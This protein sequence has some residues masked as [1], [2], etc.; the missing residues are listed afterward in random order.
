MYR[1]AKTLLRTAVTGQW[2]PLVLRQG[3]PRLPRRMAWA[4]LYL[5]VPFCRDLCP[6]CPYNRWPYDDTAYAVFEEAVKIEIARTA[7]RIAIDRIPS[8]YVGGGTPTVNV[9][10]LL[11]ILAHIRSHFGQIDETC[12]ELHPAWMPPETLARLRDA[13]VDRVSVGA[14][15]FHDHHLE[16][17]GRKHTAAAGAE[18][19]RSAV[20]AGFDTVNVD[21]MFVLPGQTVDEVRADAEGAIAAGAHQISANPMLGFPYS[22]RGREEGLRRVRRPN[23][24]LTRRMLAAIDGVA[25]SHG[26]ERCAV[27]SWLAPSRRKFSTVARHYYL[28]FGPSAASMT[29]RDLFFNTFQVEAYAEA[30]RNGSPVTLCLPLNRRLEMAY[31]LY[32]RLY[33]MRV[34]RASFAGMFD[35]DLSAAAGW[36]FAAPRALGLMR[37]AADGYEVTGRGAYWIHRLQNGFSL[38]Y[39][40]R[41]WTQCR[42]QPWPQEVRL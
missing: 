13:G 40:T 42:R 10:G 9:D 32:W 17:I 38:E 7:Q 4:G 15:T 29:G 2:R 8:L 23:G 18:A 27:W 34:G 26:F 19:V 16:R 14:Q 11:R 37:K 6:Y 35:R 21:L 24:R 28:G 1:I 36:L 12:V 39:I 5:H 25:R 20:A 41:I 31:W 3:Q 33:E 22:E 30:V